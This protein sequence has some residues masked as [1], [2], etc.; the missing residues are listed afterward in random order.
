MAHC[1]RELMHAVWDM[2][3]D[4][5]FMERLPQRHASRVFRRN[6]STF[7]PSLILLF[8]RLSRKVRFNSG[9]NFIGTDVVLYKVLLAT[10]R[11]L[12]ARP[13]VSCLVRKE[14]TGELGTPADIEQLRKTGA[15]ID[16]K[17]RQPR[18]VTKARKAIFTDGRVIDGK[19]VD[20]QLKEKGYH[21]T[22]VSF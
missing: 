1:G 7:V 2:I 16:P 13:C 5:E 14:D 22:R 19:A 21:P 12:G 10:V 4:E 11:Y 6:R 3:Q 15:R 18:K 17:E 20:E 8:R 9:V